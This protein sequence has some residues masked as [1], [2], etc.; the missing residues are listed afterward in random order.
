[1]RNGGWSRS[2]GEVITADAL[3]K[4]VADDAPTG[5]SDPERPS[6]CNLIPFG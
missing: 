4:T 6:P 2:P 5:D 3:K 1:M